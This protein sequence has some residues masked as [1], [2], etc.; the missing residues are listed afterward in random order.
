MASAEL[1]LWIWLG[2]ESVSCLGCMGHYKVASSRVV[3]RS[4]PQRWTVPQSGGCHGPSFFHFSNCSVATFSE[5]VGPRYCPADSG[6]DPECGLAQLYVLRLP[7]QA[8][9]RGISPSPSAGTRFPQVAG[10]DRPARLPAQK[11][12]ASA[13]WT[14]C[15]V[16]AHFSLVRAPSAT[17]SPNL[18]A[19]WVSRR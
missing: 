14:I 1:W 16:F 19:R 18:V 3:A 17:S 6:S 7:T 2:F 10:M 12:Q 11:L 15:I 8:R 13:A 4:L 9:P 5:G